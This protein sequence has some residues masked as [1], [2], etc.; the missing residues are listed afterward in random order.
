MKKVTLIY[1]ECVYT[2]MPG[3][4]LEGV[5]HNIVHAANTGEL[6][7]HDISMLCVIAARR[8]ASCHDRLFEIFQSMVD[9]NVESSRCGVRKAQMKL[10]AIYL[11]MKRDTAASNLIESLNNEPSVDILAKAYTGLCAQDQISD[12]FWEVNPEGGVGYGLRDDR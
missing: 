2:G 7:A 11:E 8:N 9:N 3:L 10:A 5:D 6:I 1:S 12:E 4:F